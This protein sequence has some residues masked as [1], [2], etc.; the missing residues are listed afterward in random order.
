MPRALA[1]SQLASLLVVCAV[2]VSACDRASETEPQPG[3][4]AKLVFRS[5][6]STAIAGGPLGPVVEV[7]LQ[8]PEGRVSST[9]TEAV[10][11][12]LASGPDGAVLGGTATVHAVDGVARFTDLSLTR[13]GTG[14]TLRAS[15][16]TLPGAIS[17]SFSV[18]PGAPASLVLSGLPATLTAG[19]AAAVSVRVE[20][21][22]GNL[23]TNHT[24][25]IDFDSTDARAVLPADGAFAADD[26]GVK[27]FS[28]LS[29]VTAGTQRVTA[30]D[31]ALSTSTEAVVSPGAAARLVLTVPPT[32]VTAGAP[33]FFQLSARDAFDNVATGYTGTVHFTSS[34]GA[35]FLHA[36]V[37][38][39]APNAG[40]LSLFGAELRTAGGQTMTATDV[41]T[42]SLTATE[43]LTV[44]AA[45][46]SNLR[47]SAPA[48]A[49]A[50]SGFAVTVRLFDAYGNPATGYRGTVHFISDD[51][52][53]VL[54]ADRA[55]T[56]QDAGEAAVSA[57]LRSAGT[58]A[59]TAI[60]TDLTALT[61]SAQV[62]VSSNAASMLAVILPPDDGSVRTALSP[63]QVE[64]RDAYGNPVSSSGVTIL[65]W[66]HGRQ[67]RR[68]AER[69]AHPG[70]GRRTG[71]LLG[72]SP[73][74]R[75]APASS[76]SRPRP[77]WETRRRRPSRS[78]TPGRPRR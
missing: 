59:I 36:D 34:D 66:P 58:R 55:F 31:G 75:R 17:G 57:E 16:G 32:P 71:E 65:D 37:T 27:T 56:A 62:A 64:L 14:Y 53:A 44:N 13:A 77:D 39:T 63:V 69:H 50:G 4:A 7:E 74:T 68:D 9:S 72:S 76:S 46:A 6:P 28:G 12:A 33:F 70:H 21:A 26:A 48:S 8:D 24:G 45:A 23:A 19:D 67:C 42:A 20:D 47:V 60:D 10:T 30:S 49:T 52:A 11:I 25:T 61:D 3:P 1:S 2:V 43:S 51:A 38:F 15:S 73:S 29:L 5:A 54:P 40:S 18:A 22:F 78:T 35:A 41:T